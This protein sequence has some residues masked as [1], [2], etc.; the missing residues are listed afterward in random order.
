MWY[1]RYYRSRL[2]GF[3]TF[4]ANYGLVRTHF[5]TRVC[6]WHSP[7]L[8]PTGPALSSHQNLWYHRPT[9]Q[10]GHRR[11]LSPA[12]IGSGPYR[13]HPLQQEVLAYPFIIRKNQWSAA[14]IDDEANQS[15]INLFSGPRAF[16]WSQPNI[17]GWSG[18]E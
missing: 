10:I 15:T 2:V 12:A 5:L 13:L 1:L 18:E 14:S 8:M 11:Y 17:H 4:Q 3:H 7:C 16:S 9:K 6:E